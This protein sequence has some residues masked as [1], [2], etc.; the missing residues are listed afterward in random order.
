[1]CLPWFI[2]IVC[3][4]LLFPSTHHGSLGTQ[5]RMWDAS[6]SW[7]VV[8]QAHHVPAPPL[9]GKSTLPAVPCTCFIPCGSVVTLICTPTVSQHPGSTGMPVY[10]RAVLCGSVWQD[11]VSHLL[12]PI[13]LFVCVFLFECLLFPSTALR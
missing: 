11:I 13:L 5:V 2:S 12:C 1:M 3:L 4:Y 10:T 8:A 6:Q 9:G 7:H